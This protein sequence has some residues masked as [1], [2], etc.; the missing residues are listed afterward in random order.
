M[1]ESRKLLSMRAPALNSQKS[2]S[3]PV[4]LLSLTF[5]NVWYVLFR[6]LI[7]MF[8]FITVSSSISPNLHL[9]SKDH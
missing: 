6:C 3:L 7:E 4:L 5:R 1:V 2:L 9:Y 8:S